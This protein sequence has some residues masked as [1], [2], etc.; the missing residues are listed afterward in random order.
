MTARVS[1]SAEGAFPLRLRA[2][3]SRRVRRLM[4]IARVAAAHRGGAS[5]AGIA[6][7]HRGGASSRPARG[8]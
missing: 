4:S 2:I 1:S 3:D 7:A 6:A 5:S 8:A